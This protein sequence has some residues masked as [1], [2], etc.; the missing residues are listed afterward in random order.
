[1]CHVW[2]ITFL[3]EEEAFDPDCTQCSDDCGS[4]DLPWLQVCTACVDLPSALLQ[5]QQEHLLIHL[6]GTLDTQT[7]EEFQDAKQC[8]DAAKNMLFSSFTGQTLQHTFMFYI[9][10]IK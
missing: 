7:R 2:N 6:Q 3:L 5:V 10:F 8:F 4:D 1:M 9:I